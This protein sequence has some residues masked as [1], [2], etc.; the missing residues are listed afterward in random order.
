MLPVILIVIFLAVVYI[1]TFI[2][3]KKRRRNYENAVDH[4]NKVYRSEDEDEIDNID[5]SSLIVDFIDKDKLYEEVQNEIKE[6]NKEKSERKIG[7]F[8][9]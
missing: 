4:F 2:K 9:F 1:F 5:S 7:T 8:K 6:S 3:I